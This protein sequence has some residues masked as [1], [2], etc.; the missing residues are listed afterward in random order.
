MQQLELLDSIR[1][2]LQQTFR[3]VL[4]QCGAKLSQNVILHFDTS[5]LYTFDPFDVPYIRKFTQLINLAPV[6][7][8]Q[9][10]HY[11][12]R[13]PKAAQWFEYLARWHG[14]QTVNIFDREIKPTQIQRSID[15]VVNEMLELIAQG[16]A[17]GFDLAAMKF[18][19]IG[20]GAAAGSDALPSDTALV[21][22]IA[23]IDVTQDPGGGGIT[24]DGSTFMN[25]GNFDVDTPSADFT[26]TG[27]FNA[28]LPGAGEANVPIVDDKMG[29]HSIFPTAVQHTAGFN[30]PGSTTVIFQC[31]A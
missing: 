10:N 3:E 8:Y 29:D 4:K 24:V 16:M 5:Y 12:W 26:E 13:N 21:N 30:A 19:A 22:E 9:D 1:I 11:I 18:N 20:D 15:R 2:D 25:I 6:R 27:I 14:D 7:V 28:E 17:S 23:R 31:S